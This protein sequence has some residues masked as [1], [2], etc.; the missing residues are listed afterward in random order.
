MAVANFFGAGQAKGT[1]DLLVALEHA[2]GNPVVLCAHLDAFNRALGRGDAL[3]GQPRPPVKPNLFVEEGGLDALNVLARDYPN[4]PDIQKHVYITAMNVT[5]KRPEYTEA[6]RRRPFLSKTFSRGASYYGHVVDVDF[7]DGECTL[8]M[9][10]TVDQ[11]V[12]A[13]AK[14]PM[15]VRTQIDGVAL[16]KK[17][18]D[19]G[20]VHDV[21]N[22]HGDAA[23]AEALNRHGSNPAL[24]TN[25]F[26]FLIALKVLI[27]TSEGHIKAG[28]TYNGRHLVNDLMRSEAV[29]ME[30]DTGLVYAPCRLHY[31]HTD[32]YVES[33]VHANVHGCSCFGFGGGH[34]GERSFGGW[35]GGPAGLAAGSGVIHAVQNGS[36]LQPAHGMG[37]AFHQRGGLM[38]FLF[39]KTNYGGHKFVP[40]SPF[41]GHHT[42]GHDWTDRDYYRWTDRDFG[43]QYGSGHGAGH[44]SHGHHR[45]GDRDYHSGHHRD[46][47]YDHGHHDDHYD[48]KQQRNQRRYQ[49]DANYKSWDAQAS[50]YSRNTYYQALGTMTPR[51]GRSGAKTPVSGYNS[52]YNGYN[53]HSSGH[54]YPS[55]PGQA[56]YYSQQSPRRY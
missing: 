31:S 7:P 1:R 50:H 29:D 3:A 17:A 26:H 34:H 32:T 11:I 25:A 56:S 38:E 20:G 49:Y 46:R 48:W 12:H 28:F 16:L 18:I 37:E 51:A 42:Q 36:A 35:N 39:G 33:G 13:M 41:G 43:S 2:H 19:R 14:S 40:T 44:S 24:R 10:W 22:W 21:V 47:D 9:N 45:G 15:N 6:M 55:T 4:D 8:P 23:V 53:S 5:Y 30:E 27:E 52:G 54:G